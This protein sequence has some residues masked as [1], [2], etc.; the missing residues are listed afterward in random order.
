MRLKLA[1][2]VPV[3]LFV[4]HG[5]SPAQ[6]AVAVPAPEVQATPEVPQTMPVPQTPPVPVSSPPSPRRDIAA[7]RKRLQRRL[8]DAFDDIDRDDNNLITGAEFA[9]YY[10]T[11]SENTV[12]IAYDRDRNYLIDRAEFYALSVNGQPVENTLI[13]DLRHPINIHNNIK[14]TGFC[15]T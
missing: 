14:R 10:K 4:L 13:D 6:E 12:F 15:G 3:I 11:S 5:T 9:Q 8:E 7:E 1:C 2:A